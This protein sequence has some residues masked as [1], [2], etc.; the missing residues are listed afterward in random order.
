MSKLV[1]ALQARDTSAI[2]ALL[3]GDVVFRSPVRTYRD[4]RDVVHLLSTIA[5]LFQGISQA[6]S[7]PGRDGVATFVEIDT[8]AEPLDGVVEEIHNDRGLVVEVTLMLRPLGAV[9]PAVQ[10]MG[11][12]LEAAPLPS[13]TDF[14]G[15]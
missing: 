1:E 14:T 15:P 11:Q 3:A 12:A 5:H 2:D 9:L 10:R 6:R 8:G 13:G 4:R 7:W